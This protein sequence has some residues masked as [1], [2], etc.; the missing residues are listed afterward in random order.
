MEKIPSKNAC[1]IPRR[2]W[3]FLSTDLHSYHYNFHHPLMDVSGKKEFMSTSVRT[4][5]TNITPRLEALT[6]CSIIGYVVW[7]NKTEQ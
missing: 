1:E 3:T 4:R 7:Q 6:N 5:S 2:P